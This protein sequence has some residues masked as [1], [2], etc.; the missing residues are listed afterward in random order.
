MP[1]HMEVAPWMPPL[2]D[3]PPPGTQCPSVGF[4]Q[5]TSVDA[6]AIMRSLLVFAD[7]SLPT[8]VVAT[9]VEAVLRY[10]DTTP[11]H[12]FEACGGVACFVRLV[13]SGAQLSPDTCVSVARLITR[14]AD[15]KA[16]C[17]AVALANSPHAIPTLMRWHLALG[18]AYSFY[19]L[20]LAHAFASDDR[21]VAQAR[22]CIPITVLTSIARNAVSRTQSVELALD[23]CV[24]YVVAEGEHGARAFWSSGGAIVLDAAACS[25]KCLGFTMHAIAEFAT[26]APRAT[27]DSLDTWCSACT[28]RAIVQ[29][30]CATDSMHVCALLELPATGKRLMEHHPFVFATLTRIASDP[31][32]PAAFIEAIAMH[33]A[34]SCMVPIHV[35]HAIHRAVVTIRASDIE[36]EPTPRTRAAALLATRA[37]PHELLAQHVGWTL[38]VSGARSA[39]V[40]LRTAARDAFHAISANPGKAAAPLDLLGMPPPSLVV[41]ELAEGAMGIDA[42]ARRAAPRSVRRALASAAQYAV[43]KPWAPVCPITLEPCRCPVVASDGYTYE[44]SALVQHARGESNVIRSPLTRAPLRTQVTYNRVVCQDAP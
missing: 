26:A 25:S 7:G 21:V 2:P 15:G 39:L 12:V 9:G 35:V 4:L 30:V 14:P 19:V 11:P 24:K 27:D 17:D 18:E 41:A 37:L 44:L 28:L 23:V 13:L 16:I 8:V 6:C 38:R 20:F 22:K 10:S 32:A 1:A 36:N 33:L 31:L 5:H 34:P 3:E 29:D 43:A 40:T 42:R